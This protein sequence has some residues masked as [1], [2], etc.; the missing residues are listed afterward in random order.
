MDLGFLGTVTRIMTASGTD[1]I[2]VAS[3]AT[4]YTPIFELH[5]ADSFG[6]AMKAT[7]SSGTPDVKVEL[8]ECMVVPTS[9]AV[10]TS[11]VEPD[12]FPDVFNLTDQLTHIKQITPVPA[13]YG[14]FKLTG[15]GANPAST[16][17]RID[18]FRQE[19]L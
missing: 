11:S 19:I 12:G 2:A 9:E 3:T 17:V 14:R 8:E 10:D 15:Q 16:T 6:V 7:V 5:G 4:I 1:P 13:K 18:L